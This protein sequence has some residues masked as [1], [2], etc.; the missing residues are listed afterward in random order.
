[1]TLTL[2]LSF[3][4]QSNK[5]E[6]TFTSFFLEREQEEKCDLTLLRTTNT[7]LIGIV[8]VRGSN[9]DSIMCSIA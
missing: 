4:I 7:N 3:L 8:S 5:M 9:H 1:M 2:R 6:L